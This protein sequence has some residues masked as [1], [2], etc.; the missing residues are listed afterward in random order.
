MTKRQT[1]QRDA[2]R[3]ALADADRPLSPQEVLSEAQRSTPGLGIAT[4]YRTLKSL[5]TD[6][7]LD[8]VELPGET[9]RY[10]IA[11]KQHHHHFQC[12]DCGRAYD[13]IGCPPKLDRLAPKGFRVDDH[14]VVLYGVCA[15]CA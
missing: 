7:A 6:G 11:G 5:A 9:T 10:E 8:S 13:L 3:R 12:R 4:V 14:E 15:R 1:P 2:I